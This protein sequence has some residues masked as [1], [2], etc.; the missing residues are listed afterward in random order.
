MIRFSFLSGLWAVAR[1]GPD[2]PIPTWATALPFASIT[3]TP[4]ELSVV[5]PRS[6]I[7][8]GVAHESDWIVIKLHGPFPFTQVGVLAS[9]ASPL[10]AAGISL[11]ALSTFDTDY[12]L[13][14]AAHAAAAQQVLVAA[15]HE[16][17]RA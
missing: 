11:F 1:L 15:G 4:D 17:V 3:R 14:K 8:E 7:P 5:C 16:F 2:Q 10:A 9:F 6:S 13:I 12:I